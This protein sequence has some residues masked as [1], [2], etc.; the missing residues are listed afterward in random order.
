MPL[1]AFY[2][3]SK[4]HSHPV[5]FTSMWIQLIFLCFLLYIYLSGFKRFPQFYFLFLLQWKRNLPCDE[6]VDEVPYVV[7]ND[8][9]AC[10]DGIRE[11]YA[12]VVLEAWDRWNVVEGASCPVTRPDDQEG[13]GLGEVPTLHGS[14]TRGW[15]HLTALPFDSAVRRI[16]WKKMN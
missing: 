4:S 14:V 12:R 15:R 3:Q 7:A 10:P 1:V 5:K 6:D 8:E 16:F 9:V 13:T 2:I 11:A